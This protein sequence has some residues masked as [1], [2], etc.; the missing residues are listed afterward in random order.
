MTLEIEAMYQYGIDRRTL[1]HT[2]LPDEMIDSLYRSFYVHT[3]GLFLMI[4]N[5]VDKYAKVIKM[6]EVQRHESKASLISALWMVY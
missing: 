4:K 6:K 5:C 3:E 2:G 1:R